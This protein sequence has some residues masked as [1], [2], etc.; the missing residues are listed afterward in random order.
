MVGVVDCGAIQDRKLHLIPGNL[1]VSLTAM[2]QAEQINS[3][4][5]LYIVFMI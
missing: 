1:V 2:A 3:L 4:V 5:Q